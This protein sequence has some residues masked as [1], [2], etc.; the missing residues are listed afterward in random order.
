MNIRP[1][2][3]CG[4]SLLLLL[5]IATACGWKTPPQVPESPRP[6]MV[7]DIK[8]V[9]RDAV[10]FFSWPI[11]T[12]NVE[13]KNMNAVDIKRFRIDRAEIKRDRKTARYKF[14][15]EIDMA[16]PAPAVVRNNM[17]LWAD[18]NLKYDQIYGYRIRAVSVRGGVSKWS[19]E[20]RIAPLLSLAVPKNFVAQAYDSY[21]LLTWAPVLTRMDG[22]NY[23]GFV[24]YN[25]YRGTEKS[26][27]DDAPLNKEPVRE[28]SYRD[29]GVINEKTYYYVLRAVD[30]PT[31][32]WRESLDA[33]EVSAMPR[34][35]TPPNRPSGL[36]VVPGVDRVF[37]T[38]NENKESDLAGYFIYRSTRSGRDYERLA[39]K[40]LARTTFSDEAVKSGVTYYY[41]ITAVDKSGNESA[42][43]LEKK[44]FVEE[45]RSRFNKKVDQ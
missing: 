34:D 22:S 32:P 18:R 14:Y 28:N 7:R 10:A 41:V 43:S 11:P 5:S 16:N 42:R 36:T 8:V 38:W 19:E 44:A 20:V 15:T 39:D 9:T 1:R 17:V 6:E 23:T 3:M 4:A 31:Q 12:R 24:G 33:S 26:R 35:M 30:S 45:L 21:A 13:G 27:Y 40:P 2:W 37:L 29:T 25:V